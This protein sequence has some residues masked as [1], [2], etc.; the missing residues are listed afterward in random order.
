MLSLRHPHLVTIGRTTVFSLFR[1]YLIGGGSGL[2]VSDLCCDRPAG[3]GKAASEKQVAS[4]NIA[5]YRRYL[6]H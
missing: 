4:T 2:E 6:Q 5:R 3:T 1:R